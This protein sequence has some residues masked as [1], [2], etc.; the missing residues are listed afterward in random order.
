[1]SVDPSE[2]PL[3]DGAA[4]AVR[5]V[6][7]ATEDFVAAL[8]A[9]RAAA[10]VTVA[11]VDGSCVGGGVAIAALADWV[12]ATER[13]RFAL[14][15][16]SLGLYPAIVHPCLL[17]RM[18][19]QRA[20]WLALPASAIDAAAAE[21]LGLVDERVE[22]DVT[23]ALERRIRKLLRLDAAAVAEFK[24]HAQG[25]VE[26]LRSTLEASARKTASRLS[27]PGIASRLGA[28]AGDG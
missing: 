14:P 20:R 19:P 8:V 23:T 9:L 17:E 6:A 24:A 21:R 3:G 15:E 27:L 10:G 16:L 5:D 13:A 26:E 4:S 25:G 2:A 12:L 28:L 7:A 11:V 1:M 18:A 22:G